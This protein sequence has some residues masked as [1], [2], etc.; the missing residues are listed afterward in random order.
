M[1]KR[2]IKQFTDKNR[3]AWEEVNERHQAVKKHIK[4][5]FIDDQDF[6]ALDDNLRDRLI[7]LDI[8]DRSV[9]HLLCNDGEELMSA[10][11]LGAGECLG[12]DISGTA[13]ESARVLATALQNGV[14]FERS[15]V[16]DVNLEM[17]GKPFERAMIT[18]GALCWLPDLN[19]FFAHLN[20]LLAENAR[21][22]IHEMHPFTQILETD[23]TIFPDANY[24][25]KKTL[26]GAGDLDYLGNT[27][28]QGKTHYEFAYTLSDLFTVLLN[29]GFAIKAFYEYP[30]DISNIYTDAAKDARS[31]PLSCSV[32][33]EKVL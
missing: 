2:D 16:Y 23:F 7:E 12:V 4:K 9:L 20:S 27:E 11:R 14:R 22:L 32:I 25:T 18:V 17:L 3:L 28:Y 21:L 6:L 5:Q 26:S 33:A 24:F 30:T 15:D 31:L 8:K 10:K 13:I 1:S 29:N 19:R